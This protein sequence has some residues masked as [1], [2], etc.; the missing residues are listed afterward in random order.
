MLK[1]SSKW[2]ITS[3]SAVLVVAVLGTQAFG[4]AEDRGCRDLRADIAAIRLAVGVLDGKANQSNQSSAAISLALGALD[5]KVDQSN[6]SSAALRLALGVVEG[7]VDRSNADLAIVRGELQLIQ[8]ALLAQAQINLG[9]QLQVEVDTTSCASGAVQ[10]ASA[11]LPTSFNQIP[12]ELKLLVLRD[13]VSVTNLE[14][15]DFNMITAFAPDGSPHVTVCA[16]REPGCGSQDF[17]INRENGGYQMWVHPRTNNWMSGTYSLLLHVTD[18]EGHVA[19]K[20][21]N[22]SI[23]AGIGNPGN[24]P[25]KDTPGSGV[26]RNQPSV[27]ARN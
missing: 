2:R 21:V 11:I 8:E 16:A 12:V 1:R 20:L 23:G 17:F 22:V 26:T 3:G 24:P 27:D 19:T 5:R 15:V 10:C 9:L 6:Q 13:Q 7:K 14:M 18:T 4:A 25:I